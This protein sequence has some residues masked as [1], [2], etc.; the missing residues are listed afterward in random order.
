MVLPETCENC[1]GR[2]ETMDTEGVPLCWD[3]AAELAH[4]GDY[5]RAD[6]EGGRDE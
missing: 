1:E 2:A 4:S 3:C 5:E 6:A